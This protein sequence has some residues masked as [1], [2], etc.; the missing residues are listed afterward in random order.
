MN[1]DDVDWDYRSTEYLRLLHAM[2]SGVAFTM[3]PDTEPK[4]LRV[5]VNSAHCSLAALAETLIA[6]GVIKWEDYRDAEIRVLK[7]EVD[8]YKARLPRGTKLV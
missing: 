5:G 6:A 4:H 3:G 1:L 8:S 2:Q 7:R